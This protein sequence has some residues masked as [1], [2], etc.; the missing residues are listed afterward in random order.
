ME[1]MKI[2]E[3]WQFVFSF[4]VFV[5]FFIHFLRYLKFG[6]EKKSR[7]NHEAEVFQIFVPN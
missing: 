2:I 4:L 5:Q 3:T 7:K 6:L 1:I